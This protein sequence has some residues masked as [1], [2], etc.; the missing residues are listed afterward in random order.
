MFYNSWFFLL[1]LL[2]PVVAWRLWSGSRAA[3]LPFSGTQ[4]AKFLRPTWRQR[5]AWLPGALTLAAIALMVVALARPREGRQQTIVDSEGIAM[6][7]VVDRSGSMRAMDFQINGAH[8]DRLTAIK[9][10]ASHFILGD[11]E[12]HTHNGLAG[13]PNDTIG[14]ITF[15]RAADAIMPPTLDHAFVIDQLNHQQV[16]SRREEDGTAIGDAVSLAVEKLRSMDHRKKD[17]IKSKIVILLTDGDNNAGAVDPLQA[18]ELAKTMGVKVYTIGVGTRGAAPM[19]VRD[20]F[21]GREHIEWVDVSMDE[22]TLQKIAAVT[23]GKYFR[24]TDTKSLASIYH[25]IDQLEKSKVES[26]HFTDYR[27]LAVEPLH[28]GRWLLPPVV[29]IALGLLSARVLLT[30]LVFRELD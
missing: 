7:M 9:N 20:P 1:L 23:G 16:A 15:A 17:K 19:P 26:R 22:D 21:S 27:E 10:V 24:A 28:E 13:R 3:A 12:S 14:L 25:E 11:A 4:F 8:V 2:L 5:L 18:A 29:L 6:E 30:N